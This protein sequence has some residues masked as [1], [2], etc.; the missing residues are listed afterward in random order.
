MATQTKQSAMLISVDPGFDSFKVTYNGYELFKIPRDVVD[1]TGGSFLGKKGEGYLKNTGCIDGK[2]FLVGEWATRQLND[3]IM[4]E[5]S[6]EA[7]RQ[8]N[9]NS[10]ASFE[11]PEM[12][13]AILTC[14]GKALVLLSKKEDTVLSLKEREDG[15]FEV[16]TAQASI[17]IGVALPHSV[18][19][20]EWP[21][22]KEWLDRNNTYTIE[23]EDGIYNISFKP[24]NIL[25]NSQV[26][27]AMAG[28]MAD[29]EGN[30]SSN[31]L[32]DTTDKSALPVI[33]ID[34]GYRTLG[35]FFYTSA[36]AVQDG[37]SNQQYAMRNIHERVA[38]KL[39]SSCKRDDITT[40]KIKLLYENKETLHYIDKD[41]MGAEMN[42]VDIVN[43]E[44][45]E[46]CDALLDE[47]YKKYNNLLDVKTILVTGGTG[48]I[49]YEYLRKAIADRKLSW[50]NVVLTKYKI[51]G[52]EI[53]PEY[54]ISVGMYKVL[55]HAL[56]K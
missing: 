27:L 21:Y 1:I 13:V 30:T 15:T 53:S 24:D 42:I 29:D 54:A 20:T 49:Y 25:I 22:I 37:E 7:E 11:A 10:L 2:E 48:A 23:D 31:A 55:L 34:G 33:V 5:D 12:K 41:G 35:R 43:N 51:N 50:V 18:V 17:N 40:K 56:N 14:I 52:K 19:E 45:K 32:I 6:G 9:Y 39:R 46:V 38:E 28:A 16:L 47:L 36:G 8:A 44:V 26:I 3:K 4:V